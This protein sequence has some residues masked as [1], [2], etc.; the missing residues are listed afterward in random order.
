MS[1]LNLDFM[2]TV[3]NQIQVQTRFNVI[4]NLPFAVAL[5]IGLLE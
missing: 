4:K 1:R 5:F 3:K 2:C